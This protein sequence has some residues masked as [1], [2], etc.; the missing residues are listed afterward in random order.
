MTYSLDTNTIIHFLQGNLDIHKQIDDAVMQN[1]DI[2]IPIFV[3]YELRRGFRIHHAPRKEKSYDAFIQSDFCNISE[4][5]AH[6][7]KRATFIYEELYRKHLTVGEFDILIATI[8]LENNYTLVTDNVKHFMNIDG[9]FY[10]NW[11]TNV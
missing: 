10:E 4:M 8:C 6:C 5:D 9:L 3:D 11:V 1:H 2:S 7:W